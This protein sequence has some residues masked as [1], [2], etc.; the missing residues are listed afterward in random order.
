MRRANVKVWEIQDI[1]KA[2]KL[3]NQKYNFLRLWE[4]WTIVN[5]QIVSLQSDSTGQNSMQGLLTSRTTFQCFS[6]SNRK[7]KSPPIHTPRKEEILII[8]STVNFLSQMIVAASL[9]M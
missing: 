1:F 3:Q 8:A 6:F 2:S 5:L 7:E 4:P 9:I